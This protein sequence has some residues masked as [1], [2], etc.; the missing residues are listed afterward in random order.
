MC[1]NG[2][3]DLNNKI[4]YRVYVICANLDWNASCEQ[5]SLRLK[6]RSKINFQYGV[7]YFATKRREKVNKS[8]LFSSTITKF[9]REISR[10]FT[11]KFR[12]LKRKICTNL[13]FISPRKKHHMF[14]E[15]REKKRF[16]LYTDCIV[17][18][19]EGDISFCIVSNSSCIHLFRSMESMERRHC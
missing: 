4:M 3:V 15:K 9:C 13:P 7:E 14:A 5:R 16:L 17:R 19:R 2:L 18:G 8:F 12:L 1:L 11:A 6:F 10:R